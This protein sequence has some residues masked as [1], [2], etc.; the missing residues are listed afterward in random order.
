LFVVYV[1]IGDIPDTRTLVLVCTGTFRDCPG[2][3]DFPDT[4]M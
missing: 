2:L 4:R 3:W 1:I